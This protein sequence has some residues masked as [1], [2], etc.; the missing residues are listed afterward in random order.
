MD[1]LPFLTDSLV[2]LVSNL[3]N[4]EKDRGAQGRF[5]SRPSLSRAEI[6]VLYSRVWI[7]GKLVDIP[8]EDSTREWRQWNGSKAAIEALE[9]VE[10]AHRIRQKVNLALKWAAKDGG[11]AL[12][13]GAGGNPDQ[14]LDPASVGRGGLRWVHVLTRWELSTSALIR[15]PESPWFGEPEFYRMTLNDGRFIDIHPSRVVPFVGVPRA[16]MFARMEP[17]GDSVFE[18]LHDAIRDAISSS[19]TAASMLHEAKIDVV[20]IPGLSENV[21]RADY[22]NMVLQRF[23]LAMALKS[24]NNTLLLDAAEEWEQKQ[25]HWQGLPEIIEKL[26][27]IVAGAAD[28]PVTR[29][30][31]R[32]PAGL[33]ATGVA[34]LEAYYTMV[35]ARQQN[36]LR[37][38]IERL[39]EILI[40]A[41][42]GRKPRGLFY[43][44]RSLW[45]PA[46]TDL[47]EVNY[48]HAQAIEAYSRSG[49]FTT[50]ALQR[51]AI[52]Q[53]E[54][55]SFLP[56]IAEAVQSNPGAPG[57]VQLQTTRISAEARAAN[58]PARTPAR[59]PQRPRQ[60]PPAGSG[61]A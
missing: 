6:D 16:D 27:Q 60:T 42:T 26:L 41:A 29:L 35:R 30:L 47:A 17:W 13:L 18:R 40:R 3:G 20:K 44:W 50:E 33:N 51:A 31:G 39:D 11:A 8:A 53:L 48:K 12:I 24:L 28:M 9:E 2:N 36:I 15:D 14:P 1:G 37:P 22:R 21:V 4:P 10:R 61:G 55:D 45:S 7:G 52:N 38:A 57:N 59:A 5:M 19:Q 54:E 46:V 25:L 58:P 56:S 32:S 34:D 23:G 43:E 49:V